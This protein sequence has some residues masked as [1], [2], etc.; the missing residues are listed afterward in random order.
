MLLQ[1]VHNELSVYQQLLL[2][3]PANI[4]SLAKTLHINYRTAYKAV[5]NL[6]QEEAIQVQDL[7]NQKL[8]RISGKLTPSAYAA[9]Y[10]KRSEILAD[11]RIKQ[12]HD[13]ILSTHKA[14]TI[15]LFGSWAKQ[16]QTPHSDIDICIIADKN[17]LL[18]AH[19]ATRRTSLPIE[20]HTFTPEEFQEMNT[21][22]D[23]TLAD[24]IR[25][26]YV[27]LHNTSYAYE[28]LYG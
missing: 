28:V 9:E 11:A 19:K 8:I 5:E 20:L 21:T 1:K 26:N 7:G 17:T 24:Q 16:T 18:Q 6:K 2:N 25:K 12:A 15:I 13:S 23:E 14:E 22:Q 10:A 3:S 27:I 4:N